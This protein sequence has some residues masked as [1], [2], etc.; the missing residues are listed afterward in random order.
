MSPIDAREQDAHWSRAYWLEHYYKLEFDYED[1][2]PAFCVGYIG[3]AQYGGSFE[4][5]RN[6]LCANWVRIKG[7]SR[8][9]LDDA[10]LAIRSAWNRVERAEPE[11]DM[12]GVSEM[13][14]TAPGSGIALAA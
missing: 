6:S 9:T 1:Y 5:A 10:L 4:D 11:W 14:T 3:Q 2:A 12:P 13:A 7:D 8:L